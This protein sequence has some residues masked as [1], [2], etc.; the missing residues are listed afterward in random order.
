MVHY[1]LDSLS[2]PHKTEK[3]H[4][5]HKPFSSTHK[6][7]TEEVQWTGKQINAFSLIS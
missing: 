6:E 3:N 2:K 4:T 5:E 7:G 1:Q